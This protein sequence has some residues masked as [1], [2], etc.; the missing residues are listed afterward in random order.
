MKNNYGFDEGFGDYD[1][2]PEHFK[3]FDIDAKYK[4]LITQI[5]GRTAFYMHESARTILQKELGQRYRNA[6]TDM[7]ER[8]R[9]LFIYG[10]YD[11]GKS[12]LMLYFA[13]LC[14]SQFP[15]DWKVTSDGRVTHPIIIRNLPHFIRSVEGFY[16]WLLET[17]GN[18]VDPK[19]LKEWERTKVKIYKLRSRVIKTLDS[20]ETRLLILDESQRLLKAGDEHQIAELFESFK[21]LT[22]KNY[23]D[24]LGCSRRANFV[25][26][27]TTDCLALLQAGK[28]IQGRVHTVP[29]KEIPREIYHEF[30]AKIYADYVYL[31]ISKEWNLFLQ[32]EDGSH[33]NEEIGYMLY[34][35]TKGKAGLTVEIIRQAVLDALADKRDYPSIDD[36]KE[37]ILEGTKYI[38]EKDC[39][40]DINHEQIPNGIKKDVVVKIDMEN[41]KCALKGCRRSKIPYKS[42]RHLISHYKTHHPEVEVYDSEGNRLDEN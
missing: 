10:D 14:E 35:R 7:N 5:E 22:T 37:V 29:L 19:Q 30:L 25:L 12:F 24:E 17:L 27:G 8:G 39:K 23:W 33:F 41:L 6:F 21:D 42:P 13:A 4:E 9:I 34:D 28:F 32:K 3:I 36:Y 40:A 38:L 11:S 2:E 26:C 20:Y 1:L 15:D 31:G 18:P 16:T